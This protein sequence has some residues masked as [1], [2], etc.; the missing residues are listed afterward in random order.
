MDLNAR[1]Y[2]EY[3]SRHLIGLCWYEGPANSNGVFTEK[4]F[5]RC[6]SGFLLQVEDRFCLV[7]AGHVLIDIDDRLK[8]N[9]HVAQQHSLFDIWSPR[10]TVKER[11]PFNFTEAVT[12]V[13]KYDPEIGVDIAVIE[14]PDLYL[15]LL[16]QTIEPFT[17]ERWIHQHKVKF[18]FYA[19][20][21][22]PFET[23][24]EEGNDNAVTRYPEPQVVFVES[25]APVV[26]DEAKTPLPQFF[27]KILPG[28]PIGDIGGTSGGPILGFRKNDQ[29]QLHYWPVAVQSRWRSGSRTITGTSIPYFAMAL[30]DWIASQRKRGQ[31]FDLGV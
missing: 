17:H 18:D 6:A 14:L 9:G 8:K 15:K 7:T 24:F 21:G 4:P 23:A 27:G 3:F 29:G 25:A 26:A 20:L 28:D 30:H 5:F 1:D 13:L 2:T 11:I 31:A 22:I 12:P 19:I 16:N 10:S